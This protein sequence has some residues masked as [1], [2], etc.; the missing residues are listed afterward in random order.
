MIAKHKVISIM[1]LLICFILVKETSFVQTDASSGT[2]TDPNAVYV[3]FL[4]QSFAFLS[5]HYNRLLFILIED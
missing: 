1:I 4:D 2:M 5:F 3:E